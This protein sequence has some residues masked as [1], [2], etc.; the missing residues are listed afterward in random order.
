MIYIVLNTLFTQKISHKHICLHFNLVHR[1]T[2]V[3]QSNIIFIGKPAL[4]VC[5]YITKR[6]L[7]VIMT[8]QSNCF[9]MEREQ[10]Y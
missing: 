10:Y 4:C 3:L 6:M 1:N 9:S 8:Y 7:N 5:N 2:I